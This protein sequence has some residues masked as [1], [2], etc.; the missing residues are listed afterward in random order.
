MLDTWYKQGCYNSSV[1]ILQFV[2]RPTAKKVNIRPLICKHGG[3]EPPPKL[4]VN[5]H[6]FSIL[7][8]LYS[9]PRSGVGLCP[10]DFAEIT[11][12]SAKYPRP[13]G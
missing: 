3:Y 10:D 4:L 7:I 6:Q 5:S 13:R 8:W 12:N 2:P 1:S 9:V 11:L